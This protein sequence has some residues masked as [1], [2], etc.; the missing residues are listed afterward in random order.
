MNVEDRA[1][2]KLLIL[3]QIWVFCD[4]QINELKYFFWPGLYCRAILYCTGKEFDPAKITG[5]QTAQLA[6]IRTVFFCFSVCLNRFWWTLYYNSCTY[7]VG[8]RQPTINRSGF[9]GPQLVSDIR[10]SQTQSTIRTTADWVWLY[11][12]TA[13]L[14]PILEGGQ[15][16]QFVKLGQLQLPVVVLEVGVLQASVPGSIVCCPLQSSKRC[17]HRPQS[18]LPSERRLHAA[19]VPTRQQNAC[20]STRTR[21]ALIAGDTGTANRLRVA[22]SSV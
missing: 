1:R 17:H 9:D 19:W 11:W 12:N 7:E 8:D 16:T 14:A 20:S 6:A 15:R 3:L 2:L 18:S 21:E 13:G 5:W 22:D 4:K 10:H